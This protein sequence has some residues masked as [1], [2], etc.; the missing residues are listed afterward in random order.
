M[1]YSVEE[2]IAAAKAGGKSTKLNNDFIAARTVDPDNLPAFMKPQPEPKS[3]GQAVAEAITTAVGNPRHGNSTKT[4]RMKR[5]HN[6]WAWAIC[7]RP[8]GSPSTIL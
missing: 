3:I 2:A 6:R 5:S 1:P 7:L 8:H 4:T